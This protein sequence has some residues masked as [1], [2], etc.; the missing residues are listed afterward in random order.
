LPAMKK[1]RRISGSSSKTDYF[2]GSDFTYDDMGSRNVDEDEHKLLKEETVDG[3]KCWVI[4]STPKTKDEI[5]SRKIAWI[6]QDCLIAL[7]VE[8]Y[9]K[10][11]KL[12]RKLELSNIEQVDGFWV[13]KKMHMD[14]VQ[15]N[16][17][18]VLTISNPK[19]NIKIDESAFTVA[20][21]EKGSL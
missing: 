7:E 2:M 5:Y 18:T 6:R 11:D 15:T 21:L 20:K 3:Q 14:N 1:T 9:D 16:H 4:E 8:Y 10:M 12:H 13:A 17:Q 19:Y